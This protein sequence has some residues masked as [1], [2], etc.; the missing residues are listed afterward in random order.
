MSDGDKIAED[1]IHELLRRKEALLKAAVE[2][3]ELAVKFRQEAVSIKFR[4]EDQGVEI[5]LTPLS[6]ALGIIPKPQDRFARELRRFPDLEDRARRAEVERQMQEIKAM[7][8]IDPPSGG[9][10]DI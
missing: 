10:N 2:Y 4:M 9:S 3:N 6:I 5:N 7:G 8:G 1:M